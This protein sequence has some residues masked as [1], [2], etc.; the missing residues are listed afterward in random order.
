MK[1][2]DGYEAVIGLEVHVELSTKTKIFCS[3]PTTF[4]APPNTQVCPVCMGLPGALPTLNGKVVEYAVRA[5]LALNCGIARRSGHDRKNYF[6]PDLPKAYQISQYDEPLCAGGWIEIE[7]G[8]TKKRIGITRIHIEED[9]GKLIHDEKNGTL[10]DCNRCGVPLI[11]IVSEP[12][13]RS[14]EEAEAYLRALR[15]TLL[16]IGV[17]DCKMNEGSMRC[18]VNL[19]V[20]KKGETALGTR[21]EMKNINSFRFT[22]RAIAYEY[23]RQVAALLRGERIVQQTRRFDPATGRTETMRIKEEADDYRYFPE[24]DLEPITLSDAYI[25][26]LR[27]A[28][29]ELPDARE[30]RIAE[31]YGLL[32]KDAALIA[33]DKAAADWYEAVAKKTEYPRAAANLLLGDLFHMNTAD[34]FSSPIDP[35]RMAALCTLLG[36]G[37]VNNPTAKKLLER[38]YRDGIDPVAAVREERLSQIRDGETLGRLVAEAIAANP[39]CASDFRNG[40]TAAAKTIVGAV[41]KSTGGRADPALTA[42]LTEEMLGKF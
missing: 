20:R 9:A 31:E 39:K 36:D 25:E 21:T 23:E 19:S 28:L 37:T 16:Y 24:P 13:L 41:M 29:P 11:E 35:G 40:K 1:T 26:T 6:Y 7:T 14:A 34:E 38:M 15:N 27:G 30:R 8:E 18:D 32:R 3:C 22:S 42:R 2:V 5:G 33:E 12:D 10:I 17:S 4:G